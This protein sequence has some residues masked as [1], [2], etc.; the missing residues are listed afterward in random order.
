MDT[1]HYMPARPS[2]AQC[3]FHRLGKQE[4][5]QGG[6]CA[7]GGVRKYSLGADLLTVCIDGQPLRRRRHSDDAAVML[8]YRQEKPRQAVR[9]IS[10]SLAVCYEAS[11]TREPSLPGAV[12]APPVVRREA[13]VATRLRPWALARYSA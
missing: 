10:T 2:M 7:A 13:V 4:R 6:L 8:E 11:S 3:P 9:S 12:A 1:I 5:G